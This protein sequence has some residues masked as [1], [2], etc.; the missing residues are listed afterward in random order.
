M[1][2]SGYRYGGRLMNNTADILT[3][4]NYASGKGRAFVTALEEDRILAN[5]EGHR[6]ICED[7]TTNAVFV[8]G[9]GGRV[10]ASTINTLVSTK[11]CSNCSNFIN[12]VKAPG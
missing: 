12:L 8:R 7:V 5:F 9:S 6:W 11:Y 3:G 10:D 4:L 2:A 1:S